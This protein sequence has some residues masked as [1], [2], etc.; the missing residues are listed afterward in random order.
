MVAL[1]VDSSAELMVALKVDSSA[2]LMVTLKDDLK[3]AVKD[4][5]KG[6]SCWLQTWMI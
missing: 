1:K 4:Y 3:A 6:L 5:T 2:E